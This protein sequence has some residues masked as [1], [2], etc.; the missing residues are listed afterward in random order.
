MHTEFSPQLLQWLSRLPA[1]A[2]IDWGDDGLSPVHPFA[3]R[4]ADPVVD[5]CP[6]P[7][8]WHIVG[9][10]EP[11]WQSFG[12]GTLVLEYDLDVYEVWPTG[13]CS[14]PLGFWITALDRPLD[15]VSTCQLARLRELPGAF[16]ALSG[17][18][19]PGA[20]SAAL[21]KWVRTEVDRTDLKFRWNPGQKSAVFETYGSY[22]RHLDV[23]GEETRHWAILYSAP[24]SRVDTEKYQV[25]QQDARSLRIAH[26]QRW[27]RRLPVDPALAW[28]TPAEVRVLASLSLGDDVYQWATEH[29][30]PTQVGNGLEPV[31][32]AAAVLT[33]AMK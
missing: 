30:I 14:G 22:T 27:A 3:S 26:A 9:P 29:R 10:D 32:W 18:W 23:A 17:G 16:L 4:G 28:L 31:L 1:G 8:P 2:C 5:G 11:D 21:E 25:D 7:W 33:L 19:R 13:P 6:I 12:F 20:L 15:V 24:D